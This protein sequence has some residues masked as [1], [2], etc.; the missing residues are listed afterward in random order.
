MELLLNKQE[1]LNLG[2]KMNGIRIVCREGRC[3]ITQSGDSRDHILGAG[4]RFMVKASGQ[5]I[6]TATEPCRLM[7][8]DCF[9]NQGSRPLKALY[10]RLKG[11]A[12]HYGV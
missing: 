12:S 8:V 6:I 4:D 3:W 11:Y 1:L 5:L 7:L 9:Q 10:G 2:G